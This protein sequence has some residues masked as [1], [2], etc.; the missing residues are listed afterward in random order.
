VVRWLGSRDDR[1]FAPLGSGDAADRAAAQPVAHARPNGD[2]PN[3]Q[4]LDHPA[5]ADRGGSR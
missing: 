2:A 5:D 1:R 3:P 4:R